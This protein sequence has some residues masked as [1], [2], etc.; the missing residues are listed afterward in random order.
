[1]VTET[2]QEVEKYLLSNLKENFP[3]HLFIGEESVSQG[4]K[5]NLTNSP[6]WIIDPVDGTM[7]FVHGYPNVCTSIALFVNKIP[8]IGIVYNPVIDL[9]FEARRGLGAKLN[10]RTIHVSKETGR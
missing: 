6:T 9:F 4:A 8:E 5:C 1:M 10:G 2:D 7:N 3:D